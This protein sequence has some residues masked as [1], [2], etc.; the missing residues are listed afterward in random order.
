MTII[1]GYIQ[2]TKAVTTVKQLVACRKTI[3]DSRSHEVVYLSAAAALPT[4]T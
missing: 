2:C 1:I 3:Q 4:S